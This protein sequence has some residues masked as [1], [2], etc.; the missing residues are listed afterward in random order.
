MLE[1]L[2]IPTLRKRKLG[3]N[4]SRQRNARNGEERFFSQKRRTQIRVKKLSFRRNGIQLDQGQGRYLCAVGPL[5]WGKSADL[6]VL[7][8]YRK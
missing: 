8:Y 3:L 6:T 2:D 5:V 7:M 4:S 1:L